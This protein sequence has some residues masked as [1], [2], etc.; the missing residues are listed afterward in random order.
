MFIADEQ[1][2]NTNIPVC[3]TLLLLDITFLLGLKRTYIK[4]LKDNKRAIQFNSM[5]GYELLP[6]QEENYNQRYV[7]EQEAYERSTGK[8][9]S[10]LNYKRFEKY[11]EITITDP[12]DPASVLAIEAYEKASDDIRN[13][14][15]FKL[16]TT[17]SP[18]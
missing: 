15:D 11:I 4:V 3:A 6:D 9:R 18:A 7:L 17:G 10:L 13:R 12:Q 1:F 2:W 8:L 16:G 14:I 5:L